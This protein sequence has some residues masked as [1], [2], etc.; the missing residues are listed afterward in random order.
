MLQFID[1]KKLSNKEDPRAPWISL[2]RWDR[3]DFEVSGDKELDTA[4]LGREAGGIL[5]EEMEINST[6]RENWSQ[7]EW[8]SLRGA[9]NVGQW[10]LPVIYKVTLANTPNNGKYGTWKH[11]LQ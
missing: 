8:A 9:W 6:R 3:I 11:Y 4:G 10:K 5:G 2:S 1:P 7:W